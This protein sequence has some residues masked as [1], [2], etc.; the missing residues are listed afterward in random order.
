MGMKQT[1][2]GYRCL[3]PQLKTNSNSTLD[4]ANKIYIKKEIH[5]ETKYLEDLT[6]NFYTTAEKLNFADS[7]QASKVINNWVETK[8]KEKIKELVKPETI[9]KEST[10][11]VIN[12]LYFTA[13]WKFQ[14]VKSKTQKENFELETNIP[15]SKPQKAWMMGLTEE[16][17]FA[18]LPSFKSRMLRL[19]YKG[20]RI[21]LDILLPNQ[22]H[23]INFNKNP[24]HLGANAFKTFRSFSFSRGYISLSSVEKLLEGNDIQEHFEKKKRLNKVHVRLPK[25]K[26]E[27]TLLLNDVLKGVGMTEMYKKPTADFTDIAK[28]TNIKGNLYVSQVIQKAMIEVGEEGTEAA[29][30]SNV[31]V[32]NLFKSAKVDPI[33]QFNVNH[34]FV[35]FLRDL[36]TGTLLFQG[37][38]VNPNP[39]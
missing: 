9:P 38:V 25:F 11:V 17:E 26:I 13:Q 31:A 1:L 16:L 33:V 30:A 35:F 19:P 37:R 2:T 32:V 8:T 23:K 36:K 34:P 7:T 28:R 20:E 10:M 39:K 22:N 29:A 3:L 5:Q 14:F 6:K 27:S 18:D 12:A 4:T 15:G 21:V 24:V